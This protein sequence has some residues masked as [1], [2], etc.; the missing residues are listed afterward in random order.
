M[1]WLGS[2]LRSGFRKVSCSQSGFREENRQEGIMGQK[3]SAKSG[4]R[5][6]KSARRAGRRAE[7]TL[8]VVLQWPQRRQKVLATSHA[9][10]MF[11]KMLQ[12]GNLT[13]PIIRRDFIQAKADKPKLSQVWA[14]AP[15]LQPNKV[16]IGLCRLAK[17][18]L[19]QKANQ[20]WNWM[21]TKHTLYTRYASII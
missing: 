3:P 9:W 17:S 2:R 18:D 13:S 14:I 8:A 7:L 1:G 4:M 10:H 15:S 11:N 16:T 19:A 6:F 5:R 20:T 21:R 12:C